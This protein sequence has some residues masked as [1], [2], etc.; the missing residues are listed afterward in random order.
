MLKDVRH[1][2]LLL[3][4]GDVQVTFKILTY[5]SCN[6]HRISYDTHLPPPLS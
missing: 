6:D 3:T 4:M 5:A 1:V 2:D